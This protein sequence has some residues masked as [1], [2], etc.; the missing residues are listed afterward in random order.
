MKKA[1]FAIIAG[2]FAA[3]EAG[4]AAVTRIECRVDTAR[5]VIVIPAVEDGA[6]VAVAVVD[7][8][9]GT[10]DTLTT[11]A[12]QLLLQSDL[13]GHVEDAAW[14]LRAPVHEAVPAADAL[15][16]TQGWTRYDIPAAIRGDMADSLAF[17][18]E[19]GAQ[20][21][22]VIRSKWR[23]KPLAGVTANVLAPRMA[24]GASATT[25]SLGRFSIK[26]LEWP[27]STY[28]VIG[29]VNKKGVFEENI[30]PDFDTYPEISPLPVYALSTFVESKDIDDA[31]GFKARLSRSP[32]GMHVA[33]QE[34]VVRG[35]SHSR[36]EN[37][38]ERLAYKTVRPGEDESIQ[39]YADAVAN[40]PGVAV[41]ENVLMHN[42]LPVSIWVDGR[43]IGYY[44]DSDKEMR[45]LMGRN[46]SGWM[47]SGS[48]KAMHSQRGTNVDTRSPNRTIGYKGI[49]LYSAN[50]AKSA[51]SGGGMGISSTSSPSHENL[52]SHN[53]LSHHRV[54]LTDLEAM[55]P[56]L[57]NASVSYIP[58]HLSVLFQP[59]GGNILDKTGGILSITTK[60]PGK[61]HRKLP[62][63]FKLIKPLG[64]QPPH[65]FYRAAYDVEADGQSGATVA[66]I[67]SADLSAETVI[68]LPSGRTASDMAITVEGVTTSGNAIS[69]SK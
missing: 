67:P 49:G 21:D 22:G 60:N 15:M 23:G 38:V 34:V 7:K 36:G 58:P 35:K 57:D 45:G 6:D 20:L 10:P 44:T 42:R 3:A 2:I 66:W 13:R 61:F 32:Q 41:I 8:R 9:I 69:L 16:L 63:E 19:I 62:I 51:L 47:N 68:P 40:V 43:Y 52:S 28:F 33:L 64:Y 11:I 30:Y 14:Y 12:S 48:S 56:Y 26:G 25:D 18:I 5:G 39:S 53:M 37:I 27:D 4:G 65:Q 59:G 46:N 17:P 29:A 31:D 24:D 1:F 54:T 50:M 55:Y